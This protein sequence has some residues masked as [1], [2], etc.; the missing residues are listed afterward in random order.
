MGAL[1]E[2]AAGALGP[3]EVVAPEGFSLLEAM[4][5]VEVGDP[6][7]DSGLGRRWESPGDLL[8]AGRA[9]LAGVGPGAAAAYAD[10]ALQLLAEW[11]D[12]GHMLAQTV[13]A[14]LYL[15]HPR[16][17]LD[18]QHPVL[19]AFFGGLRTFCCEASRA[20]GL[21]GCFCEE[22]FCTQAHGLDL[23]GPCSVSASNRLRA[24]AESLYQAAN[25]REKEGDGGVGGLAA[26]V[27]LGFPEEDGCGRAAALRALECRLK[28]L[29]YLVDIVNCVDGHPRTP[30]RLEDCRESAR[31]GLTSLE[32]VRRTRAAVIPSNMREIDREAA[33][34]ALPPTPLRKVRPLGFDEGMDVFQRLLENI[35][36]F[37]RLS[38]DMQADE[39]VDAVMRYA[40][41]RPG[42]FEASVLHLFLSSGDGPLSTRN[43]QGMIGRS[44]GVEA[45]LLRTS[46]Y[47]FLHKACDALRQIFRLLC[48]NRGRQRRYLCRIIELFS[49]VQVAGQEL[50]KSDLVQKYCREGG[51]AFPANPLTS[52]LDHLAATCMLMHLMLG[53]DLDLYD[54]TELCMIYW[55]CDY[56]LQARIAF[57][58]QRFKHLV[59]RGSKSAEATG[60][61]PKA[62]R[63]LAQKVHKSMAAEASELKT[64]VMVQE[65]QRLVCQGLARILTALSMEG[66]IK[67]ALRPLSTEE[68][69]F[70]QRFSTFFLLSSPEP[71][72]YEH[73]RASTDV[74]N[75][76]ALQ[77]YE[78]A[79]N[80]FK[81]AISVASQA[82]SEEGATEELRDRVSPLIRAAT[83]NSLATQLAPMKKCDRLRCDFR[84]ES[85]TN[86]FFAVLSLH[87]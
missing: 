36:R 2:A 13:F 45:S 14:C 83:A 55:Y 76:S 85:M 54:P 40:A 48:H 19:G 79:G 6:R 74:S 24:T 53:F 70:E 44:A 25:F 17:V 27:E 73:Y 1:L 86:N 84:F 41:A 56:L 71:V 12:G 61:G 11:L 38:D 7:M 28:L 32:H 87:S 15:H 67:E 47:E 8:A 29:Q 62:A 82:L 63:K 50:E 58:L 68:E 77:L 21:A 57:Q 30:Q 65:A 69:R 59:Q 43:L 31:R 10:A 66:K 46:G 52:W 64:G 42:C 80:C 49:G 33:W 26:E 16:D 22:D 37:P 5:A 34:Q 9:P 4:G 35:E 39:A 18:S 20:V 75:F 23:A 51:H 81:Q 3:E 60:S 78:L 72:T